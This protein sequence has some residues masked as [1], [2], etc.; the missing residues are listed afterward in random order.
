GRLSPLFP[1]GN[2]AGGVCHADQRSRRSTVCS[3]ARGRGFCGPLP[4]ALSPVG[5]AAL[6]ERL[7]R[8]DRNLPEL[9]LLVGLEL[10]A[11]QDLVELR[12][13][14]IEHPFGLVRTNYQLVG[15][16]GLAHHYRILPQSRVKPREENSCPARSRVS[17]TL[18]C[19][20]ILDEQSHL[21][22]HAHANH[23][24]S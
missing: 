1:Y 21:V 17:I 7:N 22:E 9:S 24:A 19:V 16:T 13:S 4:L 5:Q 15:G 23:L 2:A 18:K 12:R 8:A 3:S 20:V 10:P 6:D 14:D 11:A